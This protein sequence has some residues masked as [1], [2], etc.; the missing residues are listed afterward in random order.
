VDKTSPAPQIVGM[1]RTYDSDG[2]WLASADGRVYSFGDAGSYGSLPGTPA[3]VAPVT[4][5]A[6]TPDGLGY[7][8]LGANGAVYS[9]GDARSDGAPND[10]LAPY[11]A[12]ATRPAGGYFVTAASDAAAYTFPGGAISGGGPGSQHSASLVGTAVTP[13]GN[14]TWQ[15]GT[16]GGVFT[17]GDAVYYGSLPGDDVVP[18][19]PITGIAATPD[20]HG[21]WLVG[22]DGNVFSFG[23]AHFFGFAV[24]GAK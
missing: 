15:V 12:I 16:D 4:S 3:L 6:A 14:G 17:S 10:Y 19:A 5:I 21:Y 20:G 22:A 11:D 13:T 7:W 1:A 9:F 24:Q 2:Y 23:D 8:L 18:W